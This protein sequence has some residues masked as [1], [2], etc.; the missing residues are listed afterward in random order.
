MKFLKGEERCLVLN[1]IGDKTGEIGFYRKALEEC[2]KARMPSSSKIHVR[3]VTYEKIALKATDETVRKEAE[4]QLA[5]V[6]R[7]KQQAYRQLLN[8]GK[9]KSDGGCF[10]A[11]SLVYDKSPV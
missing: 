10:A 8:G 2:D 9:G 1:S 6:R 7:Q 11:G 5:E 3:E 4:Q